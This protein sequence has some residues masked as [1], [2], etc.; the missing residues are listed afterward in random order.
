MTGIDIG[1]FDYDRHFSI[2]FFAVSPDEQIYLRYGGRDARSADSYLDLD[3]IV[4]ALEAGLE[5]H[6]R[7]KRGERPAQERPAPKFPRDIETLRKE[8]MTSDNLPVGRCIECHMISDYEIVEK[9]AAGT[10]DKPRDMF[11]SPDVR[12]IGIHF[13]V[14]KG[15]VVAEATG[16]AAQG[17]LRPEDRVVALDS[18]PVL[19]FGDFLHVYDRLDRSAT[20]LSL[21]V[22]R[23]SDPEPAP[24]ELK[25]ELPPLWWA[26]DLTHRRW[27]VDPVVDFDSEPLS[28]ERK[29]ELGLEPESFASE[30]TRVRHWAAVNGTHRLEVGDVIVSVDGVETDPLATTVKLYLQLRVRAGDAV[31]LGVLRNGEPMETTLQT[32][33]QHFRKSVRSIIQR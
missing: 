29:T 10:L 16:A 25:L 7:W 4:L 26:H 9:E 11:R 6:E 23:A 2:Y 3:S 20:T 21:T 18:V 28:T 8:E 22:E 33:R 24:V 14:P 12:N 31:Q 27:T 15:L 32:Q 17:G 13:D 19:T 5:Q 30:V 1:L